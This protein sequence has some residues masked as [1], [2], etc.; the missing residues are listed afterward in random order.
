[1]DSKEVTHGAALNSADLIHGIE[2]IGSFLGITKNQAKHWAAT[3]DMPTFKIGRSVC[4]RRAA[5]KD[6]LSKREGNSNV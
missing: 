3:T 2:A 5:L 6:W 1:M 4:A